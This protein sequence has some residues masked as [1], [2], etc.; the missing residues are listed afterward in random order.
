MKTLAITPLLLLFA[1]A[2]VQAQKP[3]KAA[4][5]ASAKA[6]SWKQAKLLAIDGW[7]TTN[8]TA[9][10]RAEALPE[11][12]ELAFD[13]A[14]WAKA[15]GFAETYLKEFAT[16]AKKGEMQLLV[17]RALAN[18]P[19]QE[20]AAK[21]V[22]EAA[23]DEAGDDV[24]AVV[25]AAVELADLQ[26][27]LGEK[28]A[29]V[30]TLDVV[31]AKF[32][33]VRG[34]DQFLGGKKAE[35][36]KI[37][38]DPVA[39]DVTGVDGKPISL[40][41]LKGKVVLIDFW[42]TWCGPC[43]QELPNVIATYKK[44]KD[45]GFEVVGISLDDDEGKLKDFLAK[46]DMPWPQFFDGNGW[47]NAVGQAYGVQSI[48]ATYL[49]DREGKIRRVGVRGPALGAAVAKLLAKPAGK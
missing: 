27:N 7:L 23:M 42:A 13:L 48:P 33:Q 11:A 31:A 18:V 12:A 16:G 9:A 3:A 28:D 19:G 39:I 5:P 22:F 26:V 34:L 36:E 20:A 43:I 14:D 10:D 21:A 4:A 35:F 32:K 29:A 2:P 46:H 17:G 49:L 45:Q 47:K 24:N 15:K 38:T 40:E 1:A 44:Y 37:G 25:G 41:K 8:K 30:E 6:V